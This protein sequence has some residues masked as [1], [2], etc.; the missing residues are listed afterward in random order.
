MLISEGDFNFLEKIYTPD[1]FIISKY[2]SQTIDYN[3]IE[4]QDVIVLNEIKTI[5]NA[6]ITTLKNFYA[7]GGSVVF[8]PSNNGQINQYN[9]LLQSFGKIQFNKLN[10]ED[11][12]ITKI[13]FSH[14][15]YSNVFEKKV[16]N[17]QYP[18][19]HSNFSNS[20]NY[21]SI[22]SYTDQQ[23]F[24][25]HVTNKIGN[26]YWFTSALNKENT[27]FQNAPLIVPTF[28]NFGINYNTNVLNFFTI[29]ENQ[30][31]IIDNTTSQNQVLKLK[32]GDLESIPTQQIFGTKIKLYF[33]EFLQQEG[34]YQLVKNQTI[35]KNLSF[36][37]QRNE[38]N[39]M[40]KN[41][42]YFEKATSISSINTFYNDIHTQRSN[43]EFWKIF[44][45]LTLLFILTE[46]AI[47]KLI[48]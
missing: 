46:I 30:S 40:Q 20:G 39:L 32:K 13:N 9:N 21:T 47:Q 28:Y 18:T 4:K 14:T 25:A 15:L 6:L 1:D 19:T 11:K 43:N 5:S 27:N 35:I 31:S 36:N 37:Y 16:T 23:P 44:I 24:L 48:K 29:G 42:S 41:E 7:K 12:Q 33:N 26:F 8:I 38:S 3:Q 34:N 17:F 22:L 45:I 2:N 10:I